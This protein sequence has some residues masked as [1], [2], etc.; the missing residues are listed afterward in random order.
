[1]S[2]RIWN[3]ESGKTQ[4]LLDTFGTQAIAF[5]PGRLVITGSSDG[6]VEFWDL[7]TGVRV[8]SLV[9]IGDD[10]LAWT[11]DGL[12]DGSRGG[13]RDLFRWRIAETLHPPSKFHRGFYEPG[14][15]SAIAKG[16][17][18][19]AERDIAKLAPPPKVTIV[20]P[21]PGAEVDEGAITVIVA[22]ADQGGGVSDPRLYVNGHRV[23]T[24]GNRGIARQQGPADA[25][26]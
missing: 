8:A 22:V 9:S 11:P 21:T 26:A 3:V 4:L 2:A 14:L 24:T 5:G 13:R 15:L 6:L 23:S 16:E 25:R 17:R 19:R 7:D 18:P 12:F 1:G 20:S 10:W